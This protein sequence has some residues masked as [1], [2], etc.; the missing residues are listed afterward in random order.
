MRVLL[1]MWHPCAAAATYLHSVGKKS[2]L[3]N[4]CTRWNWHVYVK[5]RD[6]IK[7]ACIEFFLGGC[8]DLKKTWNMKYIN[9]II[10]IQASTAAVD[11]C[12]YINHYSWMAFFSYRIKHFKTWNMSV[13][14]GTSCAHIFTFCVKN[15]L[16]FWDNCL[17]NP[18]F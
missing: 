1:K 12:S 10:Y 4:S 2:N 5:N 9:S 7:G 3:K 17:V 16:H 18:S 14:S 8:Q 11:I 6:I 15:M 13:I